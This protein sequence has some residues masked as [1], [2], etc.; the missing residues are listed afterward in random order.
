[1]SKAPIA[2][3]LA[4]L[5]AVALVVSAIHPKD[6]F[7]WFLEVVPVLIAALVSQ[8]LMPPLHER[9]LAALTGQNRDAVGDPVTS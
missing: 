5:V 8:L 6:R 4:L 9:Q 3:A 1:M 7:T 2:P